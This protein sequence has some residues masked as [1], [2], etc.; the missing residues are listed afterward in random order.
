MTGTMWLKLTLLSLLW[1]CSFIFVEIA[2]QELS[3]L[4]IVTMRLIVA[5]AGLW[6]IILILKLPIPQTRTLWLSLL[7]M[8]TM[9]SAFPFLLISWSQIYL[10]SGMAS[11]LNAMVPI[12]LVLVSAWLLPDE[13][14]SLPKVIGVCVGFFGVIV[15]I[16]FDNLLSNHFNPLA[17]LAGISASILYAGSAIYAK[18]FN[19]S[20]LQPIVIATC[21]ITC[22]AFI[23]LPL[24]F[25][26]DAP[27][28]L[29]TVSLGGWLSIIAQALLSTSLA[30]IIYYQL[31]AAAGAV[32]LTIVT[33]LIPVSTMILS[34]CLFGDSI[35]I[36]HI[37]GIC[38]IGASLL[39][40]DKASKQVN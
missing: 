37:V 21:Q 6:L 3:P 39:V 9:N 5:A 23:M 13:R 16:G 11:I 29:L 10:T 34:Y 38:V 12:F 1:G 14:I 26:F 22:S 30:F 2:L 25:V 35:D 18:R 15:F 27:T 19:Q 24:S 31:L 32:N 17:L 28:S 4:L 36:K 20:G 7:I 33:F 40:I 8:G